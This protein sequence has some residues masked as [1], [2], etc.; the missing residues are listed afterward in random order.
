MC[1]VLDVSLWIWGLMFGC[2]SEVGGYVFGVGWVC[3]GRGLWSVGCELVGM[4][5][6]VGVWVVGM[7]G[8]MVDLCLG[9]VV[10]VAPH[11]H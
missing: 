4:G 8:L 7:C 10:D 2:V 6:D 1:G 5:V 9:V 11:F 3:V